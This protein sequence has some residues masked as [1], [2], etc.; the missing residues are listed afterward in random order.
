MSASYFGTSHRM[1]FVLNVPPYT[2]H[3]QCFVSRSGSPSLSKI[4]ALQSRRLAGLNEVDYLRI[5]ILRWPFQ[6]V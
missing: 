2:L 6:A 4:Y 5:P 3:I 1:V